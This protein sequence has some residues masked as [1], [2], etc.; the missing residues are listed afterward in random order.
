MHF[1]V[2]LMF[3]QVL[4]RPIDPDLNEVLENTSSACLSFESN[5]VPDLS[6]NFILSN[7]EDSDNPGPCAHLTLATY[8]NLKLNICYLLVTDYAIV[9]VSHVIDP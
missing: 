2:Y 9:S 7:F 6:R 3:E 8:F 5:Q 4:T 1:Y